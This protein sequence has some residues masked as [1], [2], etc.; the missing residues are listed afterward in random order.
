MKSTRD[1]LFIRRTFELNELGAVVWRCRSCGSEVERLLSE[2]VD[3]PDRCPTCNVLANTRAPET[4]RR[5]KL[6]EQLIEALIQLRLP[7]GSVD[8]RKERIALRLIEANYPGGSE[9]DADDPVE[10]L[11]RLPPKAQTAHI[12]RLL[13]SIIEMLKT[14]QSSSDAPPLRSR[15]SK[16]L[17]ASPTT[18]RKPA[19]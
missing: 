19:R 3:L 10:R 5:R 12:V 7:L 18:R 8:G 9:V 14:S 1:P 4:R 13:E 17:D 15:R 16:L 11:R 6:F 2:W